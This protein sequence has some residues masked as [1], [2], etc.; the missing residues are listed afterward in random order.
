MKKARIEVKPGGHNY[1]WSVTLGRTVDLK[2]SEY[3]VGAFHEEAA[4]RQALRTFTK[5]W[6]ENYVATEK[7]MKARP[8][9][10]E[11][12][13][14]LMGKFA[15]HHYMTEETAGKLLLGVYDLIH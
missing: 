4:A 14:Q 6:E 7:F 12:L 8:L 2:G 10:G 15:D 9:S 3:R 13:T 5:E 11:E 1:H